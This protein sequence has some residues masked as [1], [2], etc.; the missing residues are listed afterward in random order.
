[1]AQ[2]LQN[3]SSADFKKMYYN[4]TDN[5]TWQLLFTKQIQHIQDKACEKFLKYIDVLNLSK[6]Q[7]PNLNE[8]SQILQENCGWQIT[9]VEDLI[10]Y[11][12]FFQLLSVKKFPS[13]RYVRSIDEIELSKDPDIFHELFGHCPLLLD[14]EHSYFLQKFAE[15][16]LE[17]DSNMRALLQRLFWFTY[18]V[19]LIKVENE[20]KIYGGSILS[21]YK[22]T[23]NALNNVNVEHRSFNVTDIL[24]TPYRADLLQDIYFCISSFD[25]LYEKCLDKKRILLSC[26]KACELGEFSPTF[27]IIRNKYI[28]INCCNVYQKNLVEMQ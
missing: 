27:P 2:I 3:A 5:Y 13:T 1:M 6:N 4:Q 19:G 24:R 8:V 21:S 9:P 7:V 20:L 12:K 11:D 23:E 16:A 25:E 26:K 28:S 17:F 15:L 22:E 14:S 18:E 10:E